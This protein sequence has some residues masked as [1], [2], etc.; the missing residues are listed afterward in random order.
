MIVSPRCA[1]WANDDNVYNNNRN[2]GGKNVLSKEEW[3]AEDNNNGNINDDDDDEYKERDDVDVGFDDFVT[4]GSA[5]EVKDEINDVVG[6]IVTNNNDASTLSTLTVPKLK[7]ILRESGLPVRGKKSE[8]I[9]RLADASSEKKDYTFIPL[10][11]IFQ[12]SSRYIE[13]LLQRI[14]I[15]LLCFSLINSVDV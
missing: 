6:T 1:M 7:E 8:L 10:I 2:G 11:P 15:L 4:N 13:G 9:A 5:K 14:N 3:D 12:T